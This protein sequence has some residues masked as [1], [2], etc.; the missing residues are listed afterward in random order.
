MGRWRGLSA[1]RAGPHLSCFPL[2]WPPPPPRPRRP[3]PAAAAA[4]H[5]RFQPSRGLR[6][7]GPGPERAG[8]GERPGL[9]RRGALGRGGRRPERGRPGKA[10]GEPPAG[11][12]RARR[13][14][15][16]LPGGS[17]SSVGARR[18]RRAPGM[19]EGVDWNT[20]AQIGIREKVGPAARPA[21]RGP[22]RRAGGV[23]RG[24]GAAPARRRRRPLPDSR[25][26]RVHSDFSAH[27]SS[28]PVTPTLALP[29]PAAPPRSASRGNPRHGRPRGCSR[30]PLRGAPALTARP[31]AAVPT[32]TTCSRRVIPKSVTTEMGYQRGRDQPLGQHWGLS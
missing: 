10:G 4:P 21:G 6:G 27:F 26:P 23:P 22:G 18:P 5:F 31:P 19:R 1:A 11:E 29:P 16:E 24:R 25:P 14:Y 30:A 3:S 17:P 15:K 8:A 7:G 2:H 32:R 28:S 12:G 9:G 13:K 20:G